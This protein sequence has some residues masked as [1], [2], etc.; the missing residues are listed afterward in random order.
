MKKFIVLLI[1][2]L[3]FVTFACVVPQSNSNQIESE[4]KIVSEI[5]DSISPSL[6]EK[7]D[8]PQIP[9]AP[10]LI[11]PEGVFSIT[12]MTYC[13]GDENPQY[14]AYFSYNF[15]D[16][17][18]RKYVISPKGSFI[19]SL[20]YE[21]DSHGNNTKYTLI[22]KNEE[23]EPNEYENEYDDSGNL[24]K[25]TTIK[26]EGYN[27]VEFFYD[28]RNLLIKKLEHVLFIQN[29]TEYPS[30]YRYEYEYDSKGNKIKDIMYDDLDNELV[31]IYEY[32]YDSN[33]N[34]IKETDYSK[35]GLSSVHIYEYNNGKRT[36]SK[37]YD[38]NN[39]L[40]GREEYYYDDEGR[41]IKTI[42]FDKAGNRGSISLYEYY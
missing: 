38:A 6:D 2:C 22:E 18:L 41:K 12:K 9:D 17:L 7:I 42:I 35:D 31:Y 10:N 29:D 40:T 26:D 1:L 16:A 5:N 13:D 3:N 19:R 15:D 24:I 28:E 25:Q 33:Y 39:E 37:R 21:V 11:K 34:V 23:Y 8:V 14:I 32:E 27:Y 36:S 30:E 4:E 20:N